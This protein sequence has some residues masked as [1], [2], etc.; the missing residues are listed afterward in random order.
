[1]SIFTLIAERKI[2]EAVARGELDHLALKGQ[3]ICRDDLCAV[4]EEL[5]MGYKIL[6]N[7]GILPEELQLRRELLTLQNLLDVC[8]DEEERKALKKRLT[9]RTLHYNILMERNT[10]NLAFRSYQAR[11]EQKLGV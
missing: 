1:M 5:R 7:A 11:V 3:P 10:R 2:N 8:R 4:P 9:V 6:K